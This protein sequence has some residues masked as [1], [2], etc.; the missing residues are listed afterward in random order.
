MS[1][2]KLV[3]ENLSGKKTALK[4]A[5]AAKIF[6]K[7]ASV[8]AK[9]KGLKTYSC[10]GTLEF[11][12]VNDKS[13]K[14]INKDYR[15]KNKITDVVSLSYI[16]PFI[17]KHQEIVMPEEELIGEI[18]ISIETAA[19]QAKEHKK[20]LN[21]EILFLLTHGILHVFGFD[22]E[23]AAER[24]VMFDLQDKITG[25]SSWRPMIEAYYKE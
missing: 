24:K 10:N 14:K 25:D 21:E 15:G 20:S 13:I 1:S 16:E 9:V 11:S 7:A 12:L 22:H 8:L 23:K 17:K 19:K 2:I 18:F 4:Q 5:D 3:F 6:K